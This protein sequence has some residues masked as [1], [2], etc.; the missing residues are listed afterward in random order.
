MKLSAL[1]LA[2][3]GIILAGSGTIELLDAI[4]GPEQTSVVQLT[5]NHPIGECQ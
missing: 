5:D 1:I 3:A 2:T 4:D